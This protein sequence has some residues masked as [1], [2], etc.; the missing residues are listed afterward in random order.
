MR[1]LLPIDGSEL[2]LHEVRF[3]IRLVQEGLRADFLLANVQAPASLYEMVVVPD[4]EQVAGLDLTQQPSWEPRD[5]F[6]C[7]VNV[8]FVAPVGE[9]HL[10]M[11]VYE[12]G[13]GETQSCGTGTVAAARAAAAAQGETDGLWR[14]EVPGGADGQPWSFHHWWGWPGCGQGWNADRPEGQGGDGC[15]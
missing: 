1:V 4:P 11:R 14:V 8:E 9:R 13:V 7:G 12:R 3:A 10:R 5:A 15:G 2:A 6:P